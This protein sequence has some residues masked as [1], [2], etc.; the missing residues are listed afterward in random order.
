MTA[1]QRSRLGCD[2]SAVGR[3][4]HPNGDERA[5]L[6]SGP[7]ALEP[8]L[9][10]RSGRKATV[11]RTDWLRCGSCLV[12]QLVNHTRCARGV[13]EERCNG[14]ILRKLAYG[15]DEG[16]G[17]RVVETGD[18]SPIRSELVTQLQ[19]IQCFSGWTALQHSLGQGGRR[20]PTLAAPS[21]SSKATPASGPYAGPINVLDPVTIWLA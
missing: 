19:Q 13:A 12:G 10:Q 20:S 21:W 11:D 7:V 17:V 1:V 9:S 2:E 3:A 5:G 6:G 14:A 15:I 18:V 8:Q 4:G 16:I